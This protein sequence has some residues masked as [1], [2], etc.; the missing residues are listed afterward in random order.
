L[1]VPEAGGAAAAASAATTTAEWSLA[2][3]VGWRL[4]RRSL[5]LQLTPMRDHIWTI[6]M[7]LEPGDRFVQ[8]RTMQEPA[9]RAR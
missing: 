8:H 3:R 5:R 4:R 9:L 2:I 6:T 1:D 7:N